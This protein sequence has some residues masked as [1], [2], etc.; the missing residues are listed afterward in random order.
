MKDGLEVKVK[1]I[2]ISLSSRCVKNPRCSFCY[3][4]KKNYKEDLYAV[5]NSVYDLL[6][7]YKEATI[8]F[9]YSGYN[10]SAIDNWK[11]SD[12][13]IKTLTTMPMLISPV[14]CGYVKHHGISAI[15]L[16]Y[17]KEKVS[18]VKEWEKSG[19]IIKDSGL[20]LSCN[21]LITE[22]P[23][24]IPDEILNISNQINLLILKPNGKVPDKL[25]NILRIEIEIYKKIKSIVVDN[26]LG[27]QLGFI[28]KCMKGIDFVHITPE[29]VKE[30]CCF[31]E[32]C[33]LFNNNIGDTK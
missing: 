4:I 15:S 9:E 28:D 30:D 20:K 3:N 24:K 1:L 2:A 33:F 25:L 22:I 14:F 5:G 18:D 19:V 26:C 16:S 17:D 21:Y 27:V 10:L 6:K 23:F 13:K 8:S 29:G 11:L 7:K 12:A 32:D 31:K